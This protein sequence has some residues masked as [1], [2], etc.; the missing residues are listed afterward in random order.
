MLP[1]L[2][3]SDISFDSSERRRY[4]RHFSLPG[5]GQEGQK[6]LKAAKVLC[7]GAGGLGSPVAMQ[8]AAAGVGTIGIVDNDVVE[9]SNLHRQLLHGTKDIGR[10]KLDS[11]RDRLADINPHVT[12]ISHAER[13]VLENAERIVSGYDLVVD[14]TDNFLTRYL[15]NDVCFFLKKPNVYGSIL[16][17]EG[18][19]SVFA[20]HLG[21]PCYRCMAPHAPEPGLVPSCAEGGVLGI[22]PGLVGTLQAT[23]AIKLL[24]GIGEP[25][26]GR[27][28]HVDTLGM[29]F[30]T[31]HLRRDAQC[32]LCGER[33]TI[34]TLINE[35]SATACEMPADDT[36][37]ITVQELDTM[38]K[39]GDD[40]FLLDVREPDEFETA[41][42]PGSTLIP[43]GEL[44]ERLSELPADKKIAVHCKS[45][46]RSGRAVDFL[47]QNGFADS[48]NV[49]GGINAWSNEIDPSVPTY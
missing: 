8:L 34:T 33:P 7:I 20:P 25:L 40:F 30:R 48:W 5:F 39:N 16:R 49:A 21:G 32:I 17:F 3:T 9:E 14:G 47:R 31:F 35:P 23:E 41:R 11:A 22:L 13:F 46:G 10:R 4:A 27:L 24:T 18:Q 2:T 12:V 37:A 44:P 45:G 19:C 15:S 6:K 36:P 26:L 1:P 29:K 38:F 42:I 43:L 28:L